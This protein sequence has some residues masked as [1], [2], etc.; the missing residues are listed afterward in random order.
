MK[1][2]FRVDSSQRIGLGHLS[3]CL[4]L[5]A[6]WPGQVQFI[7]RALPGAASTWLA[8]WPVTWLEAS[9]E[10]DGSWLTVSPQQDAAE[11]LS[12]LDSDA[13]LLLVDHY[14]LDAAWER[15]VL[16]SRPALK[17]AVIDDL[18]G[19]AHLADLLIDSGPGRTQADYPLPVWNCALTGP[20][21]APLRPEFYPSK[22]QHAPSNKLLLSLGGM[23]SENDNS[24]LLTWLA[25]LQPTLGFEVTLAIS[26]KA[27][28]LRDLT[29]R[30]KQLPWL[31]LAIDCNTMGEQ[32]RLARLAIGAP[33]TSA[34]ERCACALPT[35]QLVLASNQQHNAQSLAAAGAAITLPRF[36]ENMFVQTLTRVWQDKAL[37]Q[38]MSQHA[39]ALCDGKGAERIIRALESLSSTIVTLRAMTTEHCEALFAWQ[40]EPGART[41]SRNPETPD[42]ADH[43]RWFASA[44][45]ND[46]C[47]LWAIEL[48]G[49]ALGMLRLDKQHEGQGE[50]SILLSQQARGKGLGLQAL[51]QLQRMQVV[52]RLT[53]E[54][55][56]DN[57]ASQSL[58]AKA[59]F[60]Q[61][62]PRQYE[63]VL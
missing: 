3:R 27:P 49:E 44:L 20:D 29:A 13:A 36:D 16:K 41:Y 6:T 12:A 26:S 18:P 38:Q 57:R 45:A 62:G 33:G 54:I 61:T 46:N 4:T 30:A 15:Q 8:D 56:P 53:A 59:G 42:W 10:D 2:V 40:N 14:Q 63:V 21:F 11:T 39:Q 9:N 19:R 35:L 5:A 55:H 52:G 60:G 17:L 37:C 24:R 34:W 28:H 43:Q 50:V 48:N 32:M 31:T 23:D 58:F 1:L 51:I 25:K 22:V 7:C 47:L